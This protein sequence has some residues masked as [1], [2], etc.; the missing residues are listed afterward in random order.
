MRPVPGEGEGEGGGFAN[1]KMGLHE[2]PNKPERGIREH[3]EVK[4]PNN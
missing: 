2:L 3:G 1:L 4:A